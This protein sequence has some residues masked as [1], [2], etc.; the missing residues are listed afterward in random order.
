MTI[1]NT[2][3][4]DLPKD[5]MGLITDFAWGSKLCLE[6]VLHQIEFIL[7]VRASID[8]VFFNEICYCRVNKKIVCSPYV[9]FHPFWPHS[10][11]SHVGIFCD[12]LRFLHYHLSNNYFTRV[13][14][15]RMCFRRHVERMFVTGL[16]QWNFMFTRYFLHIRP[17]DIEGHLKHFTRLFQYSQ[18]LLQN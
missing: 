13:R 17:E 8:P 10:S 2:T 7:D 4:K 5:L 9:D 1:K 15:Y 18:P 14:G 11:I 3:A 6:N 12:H 16:H